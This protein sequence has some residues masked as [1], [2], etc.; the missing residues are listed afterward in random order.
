MRKK[1]IDDERE[2]T[3]I[4]EDNFLRLPVTKEDRSAIEI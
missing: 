3:R 1:Y 2:K 4:E